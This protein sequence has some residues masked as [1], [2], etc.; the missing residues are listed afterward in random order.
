MEGSI[1]VY[2]DEKFTPVKDIQSLG[3]DHGSMVLIDD[4]SV[5]ENLE[6]LDNTAK[7]YI[8]IV[9]NGSEEKLKEKLKEIQFT[10]RPK[11]VFVLPKEMKKQYYSEF[12][13]ILPDREKLT[14]KTMC[15]LKSLLDET[16][17]FFFNPCF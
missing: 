5:I 2:R 4:F 8:I 13:N 1:L 17:K 3:N 16:N 11:G 12:Q 14:D 6:V 7:N 10:R 9:L 15:L